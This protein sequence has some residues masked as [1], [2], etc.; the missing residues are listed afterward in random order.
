V[1]AA[2]VD[3]LRDD[4]AKVCNYLGSAYDGE[5]RRVI[6]ALVQR[7][8]GVQEPRKPDGYAYEYPGP[9][10][11]VMFT[12]G[13]ERNGCKPSRA[14]PYWLDTPP[15]SGVLAA[16]VDQLRDDAAKVCNYLGSAYD[17][18]PRRV[19]EALVQRAYGVKG[20]EHG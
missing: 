17:G 11:G 1:L 14:V 9:Y 15:A 19:I 13:E 10:G 6:E 16:D 8:Y 4:A 18:E 2:D 20:P 3:Q 5:P 12:N 7:A